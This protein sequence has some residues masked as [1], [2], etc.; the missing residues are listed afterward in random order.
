MIAELQILGVSSAFTILVQIRLIEY[1]SS[2]KKGLFDINQTFWAPALIENLK[3]LKFKL[4]FFSAET[5]FV[6]EV[7]VQYNSLAYLI[8]GIGFLKI[9]H[10]LFQT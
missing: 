2:N 9:S 1:I 7:K 6:H 10:A 3:P 5:L 4:P 8:S